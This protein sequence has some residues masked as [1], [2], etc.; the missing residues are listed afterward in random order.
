MEVSRAV[1]VAH[2]WAGSVAPNLALDHGDVAGGLVLLAPVTH[3]WPDGAVSWYYGP[4]TSAF[5]WLF[6]RTLTTPLG[7]AFMVPAVT[8]VLLRKRRRRITSMRRK[9]RSYCVRLLSKPTP[10]TWRAFTRP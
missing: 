2:S 3:P 5:G 10:R 6:T 7:L 4:T 8:G 9:S 1:I